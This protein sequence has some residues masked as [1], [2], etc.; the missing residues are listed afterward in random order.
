MLKQ[1][2]TVLR[3]DSVFVRLDA[4]RP[5]LYAAFVATLCFTELLGDIHG[6][7]PGCL[8]TALPGLAWFGLAR[9]RFDEIIQGRPPPPPWKKRWVTT[10]PTSGSSPGQ[11]RELSKGLYK[12]AREGTHTGSGC[13]SCGKH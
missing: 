4:T 9:E 10:A 8:G 1:L 3:Q 13:K 2:T 6:P 11:N 7:P 5:V 12:D